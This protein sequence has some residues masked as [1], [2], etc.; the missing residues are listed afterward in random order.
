MATG[1][2]KKP[3][4]S[5]YWPHRF[6]IFYIA[7]RTQYLPDRIPGKVASLRCILAQ[8][9][10]LQSV[11]FSWDSCRKFISSFEFPPFFLCQDIDDDLIENFERVGLP[12]E[13]EEV[14]FLQG[15][16]SEKD[17]LLNTML[18]TYKVIKNITC[19]DIINNGLTEY[20]FVDN[21]GFVFYKEERAILGITPKNFLF[22][23]SH[24]Q[25]LF[26][27]LSEKIGKEVRITCRENFNFS[28]R[29]GF[30]TAFSVN[31]APIF[32]NVPTRPSS[33]SGEI[34][35]TDYFPSIRG[36]MPT[37]LPNGCS[38]VID[39]TSGDK[40]GMVDK[41]NLFL[42]FDFSS[43]TPDTV[44]FHL[45][46]W[47]ENYLLNGE[48]KFAK[49]NLDTIP[50]E[51]LLKFAKEMAK[52]EE[53]RIA[54][55]LD[56]MSKDL[57]TLNRR[58][59]QCII[60]RRNL[61]AH[62][63]NKTEALTRDHFTKIKDQISRLKNHPKLLKIRKKDD[64][65]EFYTKPIIA[66]KTDSRGKVTKH[67]IGPLIIS[68]LI[69]GVSYVNY[70]NIGEYKKY[71]YATPHCHPDG[72]P[73]YGNSESIFRRAHE[74]FNLED[75]FNI[76]VLFAESANYFDTY[77]VRIDNYRIVNAD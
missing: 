14:P 27:Q 70:K 74:T 62:Y 49:L 71:P 52:K 19:R 69:G 32:N 58:V 65:I 33:L 54:K 50:E 51:D 6:V 66:T 22:Y 37:T 17:T 29:L 18:T 9:F 15:S 72:T 20:F 10:Q 48:G 4:E 23:R 8:Y 13:F 24:Q 21:W 75:F 43:A 38:W 2:I 25:K 36:P 3:Q 12:L 56:I 76:A 77:G 30:T 60:D 45:F 44:L 26:D 73:C 7:K 64:R 1:T 67:F 61:A 41:G 47:V 34:F 31:F 46:D 68:Y 53:R 16:F 5:R 63:L 59:S 28:Q 55:N 57:I 11:D 35:E 39:P 42:F 40:I